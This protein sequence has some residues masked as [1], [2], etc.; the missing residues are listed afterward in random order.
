MTREVLS[1]W[2]SLGVLVV[3]ALILVVTLLPPG[4][5]VPGCPLGMPCAVWHG[6]LFALLGVPVALRYATSRAAARSPVRVLLMV[7]LALWIF[8]ALDELAQGWID[9]REP[10]LEDWLAD[11]AGALIGLAVGSVLLRFALRR[12]R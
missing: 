3:G 10:S 4:S 2:A 9:G 7:I 11:M 8:A 5:G 12:S 6:L 1:A